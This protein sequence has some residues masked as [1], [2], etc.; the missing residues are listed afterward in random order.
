[1]MTGQECVARVRE[2]TGPKTIIAFSTGKDSLAA[3]LGVRDAFEEMIPYYLMLVPGL[4]FV[5][6]SLDYYSRTLFDGEPIWRIPHPSF[7]DWQAQRIFVTPWQADWVADQGNFTYGYAMVQDLVRLYSDAPDAY[8]ATGVRAADSAM[9]RISIKT[10]GPITHSK[11]EYMPV[12][13][14]KKADLMREFRRHGIRLPLEYKY[15][16]RSFD[17][18]DAR[19]MVPMK[20][21]FPRDYQRVLEWF[22]LAEAEVYRHEK[23]WGYT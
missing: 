19:F 9:R 18:L 4:E 7:Y 10:H 21:H 17:G 11:R 16:G 15:F 20:K 3:T 12:W 5:E 13:D 8:T 2:M 23:L 14:W 1:M 22:P 6:E